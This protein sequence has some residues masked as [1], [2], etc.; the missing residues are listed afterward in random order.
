MWNASIVQSKIYIGISISIYLL[1]LGA[2]F[3][4][5]YQYSSLLIVLINV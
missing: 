2:D 5:K 1:W 4:A 3:I